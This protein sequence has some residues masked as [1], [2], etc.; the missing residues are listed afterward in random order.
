MSGQSSSCVATARLPSTAT[1]RRRWCGLTT[2]ACAPP[3]GSVGLLQPAQAPASAARGARTTTNIETDVRNA[4][5]M[6]ELRQEGWLAAS[7]AQVT[8]ARELADDAGLQISSER[9]RT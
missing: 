1:S 2:T 8:G 4:F 5:D 7:A 6:K 3:T 9:T